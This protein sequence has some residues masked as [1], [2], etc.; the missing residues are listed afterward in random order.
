[1]P[2]LP[3]VEIVK[4]SL[5][6]KIKSRKIKQVIVRNN[7][8]R[9]KLKKNF[10][11]KLEGNKI[12]NISRIAKYIVLELSNKSYCVFHLG[13]SGTI[14][15]IYKKKLN[16]FTNVSFYN[17]PFL[18]KKHNHLEFIFDNIK[19]IYNDPRRFGFFLILKDSN[20]LKK[21]FSK[22]GPEPLDENFN[23]NYVKKYL[24]KKIKNIKNILLDQKFV[25]GLGNIYANEILFYS[26]LNPLKMGYK[27][28]NK[29]IKNLILFSKRIITKA[30]NK[31]GSSIKNF[32]STSGKKGY[33]QN[34][35]KVYNQEGKKCPNSRCDGTI[36][37]LF[38]SNRST[39]LCK[40][41]QK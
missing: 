21:Y 19:M 40:I 38:I 6:K 26:K 16:N 29:E 11:N 28:K 36:T 34:S 35:F 22:L 41:C 13:M 39:F 2:E 4:K 27:L 25:C 18:P 1:M 9:F 32:T 37:K 20:N 17:S 31:G 30:I 10:K 24:K 12:R 3:E 23:K 5:I 15:L 7:K 8:L 33:F 14:H